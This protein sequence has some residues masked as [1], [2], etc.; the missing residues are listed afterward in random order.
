MKIILSVV[1][2][3]ALGGCA[4][5]QPAYQPAYRSAAPHDPYQWHT[6]APEPV[7]PAAGR[8]SAPNYAPYYAQ[9]YYAPPVYAPQPYYVGPP[10][11]IGLDFL[12]RGGS[13]G[14]RGG[15]GRGHRGR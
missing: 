14:H 6:V 7:Y 11:T 3:A 2:L 5:Y 10:I 4:V 13:G 8:V 9:P 12:F 15:R 1:A